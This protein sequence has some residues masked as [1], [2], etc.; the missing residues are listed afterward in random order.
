MMDSHARERHVIVPPEADGERL[1]LFLLRTALPGATRGA[2]QRAIKAGAVRITGKRAVKPSTVVRAAQEIFVE[3][4][5][6]KRASAQERDVLT[7]SRTET[8]A[9]SLTI[10]HEDPSLLVIDKPAGVPVHSGV[11]R[12][13][14]L[15]DALVARFPALREVGESP[16]RSDQPP[17]ST[18]AMPVR[19]GIAHRLDKDT[20]GVLLVARTP[21][22]YEHLKAQFQHRKVR[23][24]YVALVHGVVPENEGAI[25]LPLTRSKRNPL[26]RTIAR[27]GEGKDAETSF[28]VLERFREHTLLAVFPRTGRM[29]QI[30]VHLAHLGFPVAGDPLYGRRSRHRT[31]PGLARQFLHAAKLA[32]ALPSG[33]VRTCES[34]LPADLGDVL[35][36]LR[37]A[38][39]GASPRPLGYRWR[40]PRAPKTSGR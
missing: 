35:S 14:S 1:D 33:I 6:G 32:V 11:K 3:R 34:P 28:R 2:V 38:L 4:A 20:S 9:R 29:H 10:L 30:R 13:P 31:P 5:V 24:E 12:E 39:P 17:A 27:P 22:M 25:K 16:E 36:A 40:T 23:K 26:R 37:A 21:D 19:A 18:A 7:R 8:L 15:A